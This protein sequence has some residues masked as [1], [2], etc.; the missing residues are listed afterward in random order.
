VKKGVHITTGEDRQATVI[1]TE[2]GLTI[3]GTRITLYDVLDYLHAGWPRKLIRDR[4]DLTEQQVAD[5]LVYINTHKAEVEAEYQLDQTIREENTLTSL[6]VI[7]VSSAHRLDE[8]LYRERC[9]SRL[10]E[11]IMDLDNYLGVGR[12]FIP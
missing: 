8:R 5:A 3:A 10:I 9:G 1:R 6:P 11:I 7:T 4:L 2:R 12:L